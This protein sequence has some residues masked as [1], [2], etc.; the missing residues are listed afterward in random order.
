MLKCRSLQHMWV[1]LKFQLLHKWGKHSYTKMPVCAYFSGTGGGK[2]E[3]EEEEEEERERQTDRE[4]TRK[5]YFTRIV[6]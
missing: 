5:L 4:R 3:S 2:R 1:E 6:V